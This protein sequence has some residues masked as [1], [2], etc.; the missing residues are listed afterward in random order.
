MSGTGKGQVSPGWH[1]AGMELGTAMEMGQEPSTGERSTS[2]PMRVAAAGVGHRL[3]NQSLQHHGCGATPPAPRAIKE[4]T[5]SCLPKNWRSAAKN[6][7]SVLKARNPK[8]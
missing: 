8:P 4:H 2:Q 7:I 5:W 3:T 6:P 1:C